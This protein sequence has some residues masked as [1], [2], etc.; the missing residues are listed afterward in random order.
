PSGPAGADYGFSTPN[1]SNSGGSW[2]DSVRGAFQG[3]PKPLSIQP[4]QPGKYDPVRLNNMPERISDRV[5]LAG[6]QLAASRQMWDKA[7]EQYGVVLQRDPTNLAALIGVARVHNQRGDFRAAYAGYAVALKAHPQQSGVHNDFGMCCARFGQMPLAQQAFETAVRLSPQ[8]P[9]YRNNLAKALIHGNRSREAL[10]QLL[11]VN[12]PAVANYN[13]AYLLNN[14]GDYEQA[15]FHARQALRYDASLTDAQALLNSLNQRAGRI[16]AIP[17]GVSQ[18]ATGNVAPPSVAPRANNAPTQPA[19]GASGVRPVRLPPVGPRV[20]PNPINA[21][22]RTS[23]R[24]IYLPRV[25]P[26]Y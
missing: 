3:A 1:T 20:N 17:V 13:Y 12:P 11:A 26:R 6:A 15:A 23:Q 18:G 7:L 22:P 16:P 2:M 8:E 4:P 21:A 9:R 14:A 10:D 19:N 5:Y 25:A 24:Q